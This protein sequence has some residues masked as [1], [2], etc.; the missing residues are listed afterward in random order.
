MQLERGGRGR[1]PA[2]AD[3]NV[4]PVVD[5]MLVLLV[6]FMVTAPMLAS[7]LK[8]DL[9]K[10]DA[11]RPLDG[12]DPVT[13]TL[14]RDGRILVGADAVADDD[15]VATVKARLGGDAQ[16]PVRLNADGETPYARIVATLDRL[17]AAGVVKVG[18]S[19]R[20]TGLREPSP[21]TPEGRKP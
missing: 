17:A 16:R 15:L 20:R 6:V 1:R 8:V 19:T 3:L 21:A 11:A 7:G 2:G 9:P 10:A 18:V 12:R 5:V 14:G 4:T 13:V